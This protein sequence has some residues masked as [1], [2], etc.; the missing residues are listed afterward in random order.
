[1]TIVMAPYHIHGLRPLL[2]RP[3]PVLAARATFLLLD[4]FPIADRR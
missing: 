4:A 2:V 1:M 3:P